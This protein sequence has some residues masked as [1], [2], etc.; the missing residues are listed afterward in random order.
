M[1]GLIPPASASDLNGPLQAA[2]ARPVGAT[3]VTV[4]SYPSQAARF[5]TFSR[6]RSLPAFSR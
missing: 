2:R 4:M 3:I 5:V 1:P 6:A